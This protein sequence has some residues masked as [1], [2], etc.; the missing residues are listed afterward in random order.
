MYVDS[1]KMTTPKTANAVDFDDSH[2]RY[3]FFLGLDI[4]YDSTSVTK[5][6]GNIWELRLWGTALD[7]AAVFV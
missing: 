1:V 4:F 5:F 6:F 3:K 2:D 7:A